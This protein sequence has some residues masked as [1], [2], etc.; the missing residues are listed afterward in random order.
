MLDYLIEIFAD[1]MRLISFGIITL[2]FF[3]E[4]FW[5]YFSKPKNRLLHTA[6]NLGLMLV[7]IL[8]APPVNYLGVLWFEYVDQKGFGLLNLFELPSA[9]K[10]ILGMLLLD[11][12]DYI[13]HRVAHRWK[14]LWNYHRVHH[15]DNEMDVTTGYRF[16]PFENVGLLATQVFSSFIFGY[17]LE[18]V[19][20]YYLIYI[21]WVIMQHAN[22]R[23][24]NWFENSFSYIFATPDF[25]RIHHSH[26][27]IYTDSNYGDLFSIWDRMFGTYRKLN[28][29]EVKLGLET[30]QENNKHS[31]WYMITEPFRK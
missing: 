29:K 28:P 20:L 26:P 12:G 23:F 1:Q 13:Y 18:A 5:P 19:A 6:N 4:T 31:L 25:H 21:P 30:H 10:I 8:L 7:F 14:I 11:L 27:R 9:V 22:L 3:L 24:P 2:F 15:S 17:S 16:H